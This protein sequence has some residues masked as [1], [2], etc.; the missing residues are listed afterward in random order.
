MRTFSFLKTYSNFK[1]TVFVLLV[2]I[3]FTN[4]S[5][6]SAF[7]TDGTD[8]LQAVVLQ[9]DNYQGQTLFAGQTINVGEI[10]VDVVEDNL[11]VTYNILAEGWELTE[12]QLWVG[13]SKNEYPQTRNGNPKIGNFPYNA[14]DITGANTHA[15]IIPLIELGI[16]DTDVCEDFSLFFATHASVQK[17][18][19]NGDVIQ[20]ETAWGDGY[21]LVDRGSWATGFQIDFMCESDDFDGE[22][23]FTCE[24]AFAFGGDENCFLQIDEDGDGNGDF[25][26]WGW[27][28]GALT[29]GTTTHPIYAGAGQCSLEKGTHVGTLTINYTGS[30]VEITFDMK[31]SYIMDETHLYVGNEI[32]PRDNNNELTVAPGQYGNIHE[33]TEAVSDSYTI[34]GVSGDIYVVAHAV[35]CGF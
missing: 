34:T 1:F 15:F 13:T 31:D 7:T 18:N 11:V 32:L 12:A 25:N 2:A 3:T 27:N 16:T 26:R 28:I 10:N 14:G 4:C 8:I 9:N 20:T 29:Q 6:E 33:L 17:L 23:S 21:R 22:S 35:V 30:T 24:T 19:T 5:K